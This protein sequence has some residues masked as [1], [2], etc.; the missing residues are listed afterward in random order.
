M[1]TPYLAAD[2]RGDEGLRLAAYPD[3]LTHAEPYTIGYGHTGREVTPG[4]NIRVEQAEAWLSSD[5][6]RAFQLLN[7]HAPWW[8]A[9]NDV[10]QD[11]LANMCFNMGWLSP[12]G[13]HGLGSFHT[14]LGL[15]QAGN[16]KAAADALAV[17]AWAREV[18]ARGV[19]LRQMLRDGVRVGMIAERAG[20][21]PVV[22]QP[23][24][25][26]SAPQPVA[27]EALDAPEPALAP[28][29][30][31]VVAPTA[32][33]PPELP[34]AWQTV[35]GSLERHGVSAVGGIL[36]G[37]GVLNPAQDVQFIAIGTAVVAFAAAV[38]WSWAEKHGARQLL[39][40]ALVF[41]AAA[42]TA[43]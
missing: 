37:V 18:G 41:G 43:G 42:P 2:L 19:R 11:V 28:P 35:L 29:A 31:A 27:F 9:L 15:I 16:F 12:D 39:A 24:A 30:P 25:P 33:D 14:T 13:R 1:T 26:P 7:E 3:P 10:R 22:V 23:L 36:M 21:V 40:R 8:R 38:A 5:I 17:S 20:A 6:A 34:S 4:L 32:T